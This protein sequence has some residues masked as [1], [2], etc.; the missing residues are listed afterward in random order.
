MFVQ[1]KKKQHLSM[2]LTINPNIGLLHM[3]FMLLFLIVF[4]VVFYIRWIEVV[5]TDGSLTAT[6]TTDLQY[7]KTYFYYK[8]TL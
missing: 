1:Y 2:V 5:N 4:A 6:V 7:A 3:P 8:C